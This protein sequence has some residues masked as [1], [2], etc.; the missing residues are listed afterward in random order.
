LKRAS[1]KTIS[2][3]T[4]KHKKVGSASIDI[5]NKYVKDF[6]VQRSSICSQQE[7]R[8]SNSRDLLESSKS[9]HQLPNAFSVSPTM[10][11]PYEKKRK[12]SLDGTSDQTLKFFETTQEE[13][14]SNTA[15]KPFLKIK[16]TGPKLNSF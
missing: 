6:I 10:I 15:K 3:K 5:D 8:R 13:I 16:L 1:Q 2:L 12:A 7:R 14:E 11:R 4:K 9:S